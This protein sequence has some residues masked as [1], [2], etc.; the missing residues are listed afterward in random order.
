MPHQPVAPA[1]TRPAP[2]RPGMARKAGCAVS[3][4]MVPMATGEPAT[5]C[6]CRMMGMRLVRSGRMT[7]WPAS[8]RAWMPPA[9]WKAGLSAVAN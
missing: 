4:R 9:R 7:G 8:F 3:P 6:T 5:I 2:T 1:N